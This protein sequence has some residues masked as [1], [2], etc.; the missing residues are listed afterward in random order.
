MRSANRE[1]SLLIVAIRS[2]KND[3]VIEDLDRVVKIDPVFDAIELVLLL[4]PIESSQNQFS[5]LFVRHNPHFRPEE[6]AKFIALL[7]G[8]G[9]PL[10]R[11][12]LYIQL[13]FTRVKSGAYSRC[14]AGTAPP[15]VNSG[16]KADNLR[17]SPL[18]P[19]YP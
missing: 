6:I 10:A 5:Y 9:G 13:Y 8:C 4:V 7:L 16:K 14:L 11:R 3:W 19:L 17:I 18:A 2:A 12:E 15:P 1:P